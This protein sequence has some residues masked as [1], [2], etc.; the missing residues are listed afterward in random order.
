MAAI[1]IG[2]VKVEAPSEY[3]VKMVVFTAPMK[4]SKAAGASPRFLQ[5]ERNFLR[6]LVVANEDLKEGTSLD[7]YAAKQVEVLAVQIPGFKRVKNDRVEIMGTSCPIIESTGAGPEGLA[8]TTITAFFAKE[9][10][11]WT[12]SA[13]NLTGI[14]FQDTRAEYLEIIK[15][16]QILD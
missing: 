2:G 5:K 15:S 6:N 16:F 12:I 11:V 3:A 9:G 13:S 7:D 1:M 8:L 14:Q 4:T 10:T